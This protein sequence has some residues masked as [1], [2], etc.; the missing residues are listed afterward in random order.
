[1]QKFS[2]M[3]GD[4]AVEGIGETPF[5]YRAQ[6]PPRPVGRPAVGE[7]SVEDQ[8]FQFHARQLRRKRARDEPRAAPWNRNC[9]DLI[10]RALVAQ[11]AFLETPAPAHKV[12]PLP[13]GKAVLAARCEARFEQVRDC[14]INIVAT[15]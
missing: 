7:K 15:E 11:H 8:L 3:P 12:I 9:K 2:E 13:G 14:E 1:M 4:R 5:P 6:R 10:R